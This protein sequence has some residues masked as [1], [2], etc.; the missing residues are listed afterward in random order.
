MFENLPGPDVVLAVVRG[1]FRASQVFLKPCDLPFNQPL[2][3]V[4][5]SQVCDQPF[6]EIPFRHFP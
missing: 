1:E 2:H 6:E 3:G 4:S 5:G